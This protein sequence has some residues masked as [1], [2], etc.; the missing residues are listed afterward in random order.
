MSGED[1]RT[2]G[3]TSDNAPVVSRWENAIEQDGVIASICDAR[4]ILVEGDPDSRS[5][6][7]VCMR[8]GVKLVALLDTDDLYASGEVVKPSIYEWVSAQLCT[9]HRGPYIQHRDARRCHID[10]CRRSG[11]SIALFGTSTKRCRA[12]IGKALMATATGQRPQV[13]G[14]GSRREHSETNMTQC[15]D[16][17][18]N[19]NAVD[20]EHP[21]MFIPS[22]RRPSQNSLESGGV[23][24]ASIIS[25]TCAA[26]DQLHT[27]SRRKSS[28]GPTCWDQ[29]ISD[30]P[31]GALPLSRPSSGAAG[32][33][34]VS[35]HATPPGLILPPQ[36]VSTPSLPVPYPGIGQV[37]LV[38][39]ARAIWI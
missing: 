19:G 22:S 39:S 30:R 7:K 10:G 2:S 1:E 37:C 38:R 3:S 32:G 24:A 25:D 33:G 6:K 4:S 17:Q 36:T 35:G 26:L 20:D 16:P 18:V 11:V 12:R 21:P 15:F 29:D 27:T 9:F 14:T 23:S 13:A 31:V 5:G 34:R 28:M 8:P